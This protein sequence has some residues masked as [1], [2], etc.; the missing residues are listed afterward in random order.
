[1]M[2]LP[3]LHAP[4]LFATETKSIQTTVADVFHE[5]ALF[6]RSPPAEPATKGVVKAYGGMDVYITYC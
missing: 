4:R 2:R 3:T 1:M 5:D 6:L